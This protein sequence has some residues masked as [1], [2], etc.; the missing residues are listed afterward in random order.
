MLTK[1]DIA[2]PEAPYKMI[3][4]GNDK[5]AI[6]D[7]DDFERISKFHWFARITRYNC[8]AVRKVCSK[9]SEFLVPMHRQ[10]MFTPKNEVVHHINHNGLDNRKE[11]LL[12]MTKLQHH[13]LHRFQ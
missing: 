2:D 6:V 13:E 3:V 9:N 8:Y 1:I 5:I 11:N 4:L 10:I 7:V 12:N